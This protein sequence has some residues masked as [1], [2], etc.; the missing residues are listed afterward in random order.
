MGMRAKVV[1]LSAEQLRPGRGKLS[2]TYRE[3]GLTRHAARE[4]KKGALVPRSLLLWMDAL[5]LSHAPRVLQGPRTVSALRGFG[6]GLESSFCCRRRRTVVSELLGGG[7]RAV[8]VARKELDNTLV[9][10]DGT[11]N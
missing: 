10:D 7:R 9:T 11:T 2:E 5:T 4:R 1:S 6:S 3:R 8:A